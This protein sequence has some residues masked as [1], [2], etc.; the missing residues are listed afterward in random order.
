MVRTSPGPGLRPP[1]TGSPTRTGL[2]EHALHAVRG[3]STATASTTS[4]GRWWWSAAS[5]EPERR[6]CS[7]LA[8]CTWPSSSTRSD[9]DGACH[10]R[11][12][13]R[14][15]LDRR[16]GTSATGGA[17][18]SGASAPP[19]ARAATAGHAG[20]RRCIGLPARPPGARSPHRRSM[21]F[22]ALGAG[23]VLRGR[24][25]RAAARDAARRLRRLRSGAGRRH[26]PGLALAGAAAALRQRRRS[27]RRCWSPGELLPD[28]ARRCTRGLDL[29]EFLLRHRDPRRPP[30]GDAGRRPRTG[31]TPVP[32][33]TSSR[34]RWP[35]SPTPA[36][37]RTG[38][39]ATRAG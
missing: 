30:V 4:P 12:T 24:P 3:P 10:N 16:A 38:S 11:M 25:E 17:G 28:A 9:P 33:S 18:R 32:A 5:R 26:R 35:R 14:R 31:P 34:S 7:R 37:A 15:R 23:E 27:P 19:A 13:R 21:A 2:F 8:G 6:R 20:P 22:A 1:A 36:H 29:L 39:P